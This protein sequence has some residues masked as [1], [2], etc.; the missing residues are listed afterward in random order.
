MLDIQI[1]SLN[2]KKLVERTET[3][4][5]E[6]I[7]VYLSLISNRSSKKLDYSRPIVIIYYPG[8]DKCNSH[9]YPTKKSLKSWYLTLENGIQ[10]QNANAPI[11]LYKENE[12]LDRYEGIIEW[13]KDPNGMTEKL[14]FNY[15]YLCSSFVVISPNGK[16]I[17][18]FGEF[19][20][21]YVWNAIALI[22]T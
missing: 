16:Y 17:S 12:G 13:Y 22:S 3:G 9:A 4:K 14:F 19:G 6:N 20:Q 5:V 21:N 1:D 10:D 2:Q 18:Y 15:H 8:K 11:Y 7:E